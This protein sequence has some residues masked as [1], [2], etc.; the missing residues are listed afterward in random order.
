MRSK[1]PTGI[2]WKPQY[3]TGITGQSSGRGRWVTPKVC[4]A[5]M[6]VPT[7]ERSAAVQPEA[8]SSGV[9]IGVVARR[10]PFVVGDTG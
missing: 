10:P 1:N 7:S 2:R 3:S 4:Q 5:T 9:L 8:V 6:S